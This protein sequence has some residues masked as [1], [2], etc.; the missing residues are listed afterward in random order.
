MKPFLSHCSQ[1]PVWAFL[2][3]P[4]HIWSEKVLKRGGYC[5]IETPLTLLSSLV[6]KAGAR[7]EKKEGGRTKKKREKRERKEKRRNVRSHFDF[8]EQ[9]SINNTHLE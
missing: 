3:R 9:I 4:G 2:A 5:L 1:Q 8:L 7:E 6:L